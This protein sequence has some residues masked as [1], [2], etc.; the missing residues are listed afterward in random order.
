MKNDQCSGVYDSSCDN[1]GTVYLCDKVFSWDTSSSSCVYYESGVYASSATASNTCPDG[2]NYIT[3]ESLCQHAVYTHVAGVE[4]Y[5]KAFAFGKNNPTGC[6]MSPWSKKAWSNTD[7]GGAS[8][9]HKV[10]CSKKIFWPKVS[11]QHCANHQFGGPIN[12][13]ADAMEVCHL[14]SPHCN[15]VYDDM[16]DDKGYSLCDSNYEWETSGSGSCVYHESWE[17]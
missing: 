10:I 1:S 3:S 15:G 4:K 14:H 2:F 6:H 5:D 16:C 7:A 8:G 12:N 11:S 17:H 13:F 9:S